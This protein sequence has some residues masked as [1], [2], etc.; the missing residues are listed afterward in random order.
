[1]EG[2]RSE[3]LFNVSDILSPLGPR[4]SFDLSSVICRKMQFVW[5]VPVRSH[6]GRNLCFTG[7]IVNCIDIDL[8]T[9]DESGGVYIGWVRFA[10]FGGKLKSV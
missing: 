8:E 4:R 2:H 10:P 5:P 3:D 7:G 9:L 1:M 6:L